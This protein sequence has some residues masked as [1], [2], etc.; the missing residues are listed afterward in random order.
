MRLQKKVHKD[1]L[2]KMRVFIPVF[3]INAH[4]ASCIA[5]YHPRNDASL[6][7]VD[8]EAVERMW[9]QLSVFSH[10]SRNMSSGNRRELLE[11]AIAEI[12]QKTKTNLLKNLNSKI[13]KNDQILNVMQHGKHTSNMVG[14]HL[15][16][17]FEFLFA[18]HDVKE[19][20]TLVAEDASLTPLDV[21][22]AELK[23]CESILKTRKV[24]GNS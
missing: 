24:S 5:L 12:R 23:F 18:H 14:L 7:D 21:V 11:D 17:A 4:R 15:M 3:H 19:L 9:S 16:H 2:E 13:R 22:M 6:G 1:T 8:G 20:A 10:T